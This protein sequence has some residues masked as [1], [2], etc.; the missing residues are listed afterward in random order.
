MSPHP[1]PPLDIVAVAVALAG[2]LFGNDMAEIIGPY[3]VIFVA[4]V[5]GAAWSA[6]RRPAV[7]RGSTV[8]YLIFFIVAAVLVTVPC[9]E[10]AASYLP[11]RL[12]MRIL[13]PGVAFTIAG[14]GPDWPGVLEAVSKMYLLRNFSFVPLVYVGNKLFL[15]SYSY[16]D[17]YL[18]AVRSYVKATHP[19]TAIKQVVRYGFKT[20][21]LKPA[22][23]AW[24]DVV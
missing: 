2:V 9:A 4:A 20:L 1:P 8:A 18:E 17:K 21:T 16:H 15:C 19:K 23:A 6:T 7:G 22:M 13:L 14:I 5:L 10:I 3:A 24:E 11:S 12:G